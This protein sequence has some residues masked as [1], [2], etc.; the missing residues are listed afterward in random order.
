MHA[1]DL[2]RQQ[3]RE[4]RVLLKE[5]LRA[6]SPR[7]RRALLHEIA[8]RLEV[9]TRIE[10]EI[11]YPALRAEGGGGLE[12]LVLEAYEQHHIVDLVLRDLVR[13]DAGAERFAA[14]LSVFQEL[15]EHHVEE[16][17]HEMFPAAERKLAA[18][19]L[20]EL[21]RRMLEKAEACGL[22]IS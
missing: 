16:E 9:H 19:R 7:E 3:H 14:K 20:E 15:I 6:D 13:A 12:L 22:G 10:E 1:T 21:G 5:V 4:L 8:A 2:L 18:R 17:E 11:F